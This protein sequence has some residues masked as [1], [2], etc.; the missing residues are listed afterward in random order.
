MVLW[1]VAGLGPVCSR[2][3][4]LTG[5]AGEL[6]LLLSPKDLLPSVWPGEADCCT[7]PRNSLEERAFALPASSHSTLSPPLWQSSREH[8]LNTRSTCSFLTR[9]HPDPRTASSRATV[10]KSVFLEASPMTEVSLGTGGL[11]FSTQVHPWCRG[12]ACKGLGM[13][14][15]PSLCPLW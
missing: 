7:D 3:S 1:G 12:R 5:R 13:S 4:G 8:G 9:G 15:V 14:V 11:L 10:F 6:E 2:D